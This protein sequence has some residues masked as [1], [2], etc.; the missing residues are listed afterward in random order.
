VWYWQTDKSKRIKAEKEEK[1][2]SEVKST[3]RKKV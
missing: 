3:D 1:E 2:N